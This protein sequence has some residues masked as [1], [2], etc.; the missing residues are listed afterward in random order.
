MYA[1]KRSVAKTQGTK[2][3]RSHRINKIR[4]RGMQKDHIQITPDGKVIQHYKMDTRSAA[5]MK[6]F[7]EAQV[8]VNEEAKDTEN[9]DSGAP[10]NE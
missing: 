3:S 4:H 5:V 7:K 9:V 6:A 10:K 1:S 2:D 8:K